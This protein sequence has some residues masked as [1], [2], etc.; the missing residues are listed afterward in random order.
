MGTDS[1]SPYQSAPLHTQPFAGLHTPH[2]AA[3]FWPA[4]HRAWIRP[5]V[6]AGSLLACS[7]GQSYTLGPFPQPQPSPSH[8]TAPTSMSCSACADNIVSC[9]ACALCRHLGVATTAAT[10]PAACTD[11]SCAPQRG[12]HS[13]G[14]QNSN[15]NIWPH[16]SNNPACS[17]GGGPTRD[18]YLRT[19]QWPAPWRNSCQC[20]PAC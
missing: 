6:A 3:G 7:K 15:Q 16:T 9:S 5:P 11:T 2:A 8:G 17:T 12:A 20:L 4:L 14:V 10:C 1:S 18:H 13:T 19:L